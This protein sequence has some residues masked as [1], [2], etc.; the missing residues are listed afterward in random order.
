MSHSGPNNKIFGG[1]EEVTW[2][3]PAIREPAASK[4]FASPEKT[5]LK[6]LFFLPFSVCN[7]VN[8]FERGTVQEKLRPA[9][10]F[11]FHCN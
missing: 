8:T 9:L 4:W 3:V 10:L 11:A 6:N 5:R 2:E 7:A 1:G